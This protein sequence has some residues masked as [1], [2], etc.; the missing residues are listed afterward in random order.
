MIFSQWFIVIGFIGAIGLVR[1]YW[2]EKDSDDVRYFLSV[3][4]NKFQE[5]Y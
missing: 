1:F 4:V 3:I 2:S 5:V